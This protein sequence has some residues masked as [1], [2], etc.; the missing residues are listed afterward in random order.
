MTN[1]TDKKKSTNNMNISN[2]QTNIQ[3]TSKEMAPADGKQSLATA[4]KTP[5][6]YFWKRR[7]SNPDLLDKGKAPLHYVY[8]DESVVA[9]RGNFHRHNIVTLLCQLRLFW[10]VLDIK[11]STPVW[12]DL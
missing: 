1:I 12:E 2:K 4:E 10:V 6:K 7:D 9:K 3:T 5:K 11:S 8:E